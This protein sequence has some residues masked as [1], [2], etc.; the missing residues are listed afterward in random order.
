MLVTL[1]TSAICVALYTPLMTAN[2]FGL[3]V[4]VLSFSTF[5]TLLELGKA[6]S[7]LTKCALIAGGDTITLRTA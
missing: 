7:F 3:C 6:K 1:K 5:C 4:R 2:T